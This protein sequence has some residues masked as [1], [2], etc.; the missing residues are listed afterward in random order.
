MKVMVIIIIIAI[1]IASSFIIKQAVDNKLYFGLLT[2]FILYSTCTLL[3][4]EFTE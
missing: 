2:I 4:V 3:S 1:A